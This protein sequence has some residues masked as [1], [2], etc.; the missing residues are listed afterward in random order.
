MAETQLLCVMR[1]NMLQQVDMPTQR[2][3]DTLPSTQGNTGNSPGLQCSFQMLASE[4]EYCLSKLMKD[5]LDP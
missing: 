2:K 5:V 1:S 4:L 3:W